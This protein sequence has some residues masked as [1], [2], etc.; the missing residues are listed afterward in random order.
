[1]YQPKPDFPPLF[2]NVGWWRKYIE[3]LLAGESRPAAISGANAAVAPRHWMRFDGISL[4]VAGGQS[5][6]KNH[7]PDSWRIAPKALLES[8]KMDA[9][10]ATRYGASPYYRLL[11]HI[12]SLRDIV[13]DRLWAR[14]VCLEAFRRIEGLLG[15]DD[16]ELIK[17]AKKVKLQGGHT[18]KENEEILPLI[19]RK[20]KEAIFYLLPTFNLNESSDQQV[21]SPS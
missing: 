8:P 10:L 15:L 14:Q 13:A 5:T 4:P 17:A 2:P 20:G 12:F 9:T 16:P 19:F 18:V 21:Q 11:D 7:R 6:L 3:A 1:M